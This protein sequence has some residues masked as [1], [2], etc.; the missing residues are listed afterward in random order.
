MIL[1]D[2]KGRP[3]PKPEP[4]AEDAGV[5]ETIAYIRAVHAYNDR[6]SDIANR[7]FAEA[8]SKAVSS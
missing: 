1:T 6:V 7:A 3:V 4:P 5:E 2:A 8:F